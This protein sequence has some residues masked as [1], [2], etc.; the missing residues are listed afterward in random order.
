[1]SKIT[2]V[3]I[4]GSRNDQIQI[5]LDWEGFLFDNF[6]VATSVI[7][8]EANLAYLLGVYVNAV[9][10]PHGLGTTDEIAILAN[11]LASNSPPLVT[12]LALCIWLGTDDESGDDS[13][14]ALEGRMYEVPKEG[15][16]ST[17]ATGR[18]RA[19]T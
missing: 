2:L 10:G 11:E 7:L 18:S 19:A 13:E 3:C 6:E 4:Q 5:W 14:E 16:K 15:E 17:F 1:L 9:A 8:I 12:V